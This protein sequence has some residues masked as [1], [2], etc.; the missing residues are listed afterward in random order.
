[1]SPSVAA[2]V[3]TEDE[4]GAEVSLT[5]SF[6]A[7]YPPQVIRRRRRGLEHSRDDEGGD[8]LELAVSEQNL[9]DEPARR[10][11][12]IVEREA[13]ARFRALHQFQGT[14]V[15]ILDDEFVARTRDITDPVYAEE[16]VTLPLDDIPP[17]DQELL[18][19]GAVFYWLIGYEENDEGARKRT[20]ILRFRRLPAWSDRAVKR[21][22]AAAD[23]LMRLFGDGK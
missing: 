5:A 7:Q 6:P 14:V 4:L 1:M 17:G 19:V 9:L 18:E 10:R 15:E 3:E 13:E 8:G 11:P 22:E 21:V 12:R 20:S 23:D 2:A 16:V